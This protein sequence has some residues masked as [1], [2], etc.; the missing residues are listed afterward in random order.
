MREVE[1]ARSRGGRREIHLSEDVPGRGVQ[2]IQTAIGKGVRRRIRVTDDIQR[3]RSGVVCDRPTDTKVPCRT[4]RREGLLA[5]MRGP[6][7]RA[8]ESVVPINVSAAAAY[9]KNA[10]VA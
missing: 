8:R 3:L 7:Q 1:F 6:E 4:T 9:E 5:D 2:M 10:G